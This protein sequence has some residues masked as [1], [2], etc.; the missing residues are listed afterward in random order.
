[1]IVVTS[2]LHGT[3]AN[4]SFWAGLL[5]SLLNLPVIRRL[6]CCTPAVHEKHTERPSGRGPRSARV[7]GAT[8]VPTP[9]NS[10]GLHPRRDQR[11]PRFTYHPSSNTDCSDEFTS[12]QSAP[13]P[14]WP[15]ARFFVLAPAFG[16]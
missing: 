8:S 3:Y 4:R 7:A 11:A 2:C 15:F 12:L 1:M 9:S 10:R 13:P 16:R 14:W 6:E 5:I